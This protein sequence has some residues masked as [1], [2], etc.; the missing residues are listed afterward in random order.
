MI[1]T[2]AT[3]NPV[4]KRYNHAL[5]AR[6][7]NRNRYEYADPLQRNAADRER[8]SRSQVRFGETIITSTDFHLKHDEWFENAVTYPTLP[9]K[10]T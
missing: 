9:V 3:P 7:R 6:H 5:H 10:K 2:T 8:R 1:R 4:L